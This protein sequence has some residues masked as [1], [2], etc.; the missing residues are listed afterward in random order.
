[1]SLHGSG[2]GA[3]QGRWCVG[4]NF[5]N[6]V[7]KR[8]GHWGMVFLNPEKRFWVD[9]C[10]FFRIAG[11]ETEIGRCH[12]QLANLEKSPSSVIHFSSVIEFLSIS[13]LK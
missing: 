7:E 3:R 1:L 8:G 5:I 6:K 11:G 12:V 9:G 2:V 13:G 10:N 4:V